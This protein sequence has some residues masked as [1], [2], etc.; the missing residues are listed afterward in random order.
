MRPVTSDPAGITGAP[1]SANNGEF[2]DA[3]NVDPVWL[4]SVSMGSIS[5]IEIVVPLGI[6][7]GCTGGGVGFTAG[8]GRVGAET[9]LADADGEFADA[10][11][12]LSLYEVGKLR[13]LVLAPWSVTVYGR[14]AESVVEV[15]GRREVWLCEV[16]FRLGDAF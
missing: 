8:A 13:G 12:A 16:C 2:K 10:G 9:E 4:F 1:D 3:R 14:A 15:V 5:R 7:T 11:A 6:V